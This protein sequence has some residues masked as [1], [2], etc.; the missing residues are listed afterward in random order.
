MNNETL[1][2]AAREILL[3][4]LQKLED[5]HQKFFI[6]MYFHNNKEISVEEAVQ[7]LPV[8]KIDW[9]ITQAEATLKKV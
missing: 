7:K 9:A 4:A 2:A 1:I 3:K 6:Q 8:E 5:K